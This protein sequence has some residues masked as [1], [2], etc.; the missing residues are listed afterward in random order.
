MS[1]RL[2]ALGED[3]QL[4]VAVL[5]CGALLAHCRTRDGLKRAAERL[6]IMTY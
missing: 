3:N 1:P 4:T 5:A 6:V 2:Q